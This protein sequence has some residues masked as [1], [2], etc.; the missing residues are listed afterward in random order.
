MEVPIMRGELSW[1]RVLGDLG[2][3][4]CQ[5]IRPVEPVVR[6]KDRQQGGA[7]GA[8]RRCFW[9]L[10]AKQNVDAGGDR[11]G[12]GLGVVAALEEER[13]AAPAVAIREISD[14][15][16]EASEALTTE[17]KTADWVVAMAVKT[18]GNENQ[19]GFK[20]GGENR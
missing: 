9:G 13:Q 2:G 12:G 6:P 1:S 5:E 17:I 16:A 11:A 10:C 4:G 3:F 18:G 7:A 20:I 14:L 15:C 8:H 19:I